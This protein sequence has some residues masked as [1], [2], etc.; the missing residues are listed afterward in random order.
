MVKTTLR[1]NIISPEFKANPFPFLAS[2]SFRE[3]PLFI[4]SI[5]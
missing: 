2:V 1:V 5:W 3:A 4:F